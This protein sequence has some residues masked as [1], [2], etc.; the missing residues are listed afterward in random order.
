[1]LGALA[2]PWRRIA[3]PWIVS[4]RAGAP[5]SRRHPGWHL[6]PPT[7]PNVSAEESGVRDPDTCGAAG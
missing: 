2:R 4:F 7:R 3:Q 1:V 5:Q 6:R